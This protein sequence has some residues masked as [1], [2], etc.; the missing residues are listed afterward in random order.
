[1]L[2]SWQHIKRMIHHDQMGLILGIQDW[3]NLLGVYDRFMG[4]N[5]QVKASDQ[6]KTLHL[7]LFLFFFY[8]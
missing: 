2:L 3:F 1:M 8:W 4:K 5:Y 7:F 6:G